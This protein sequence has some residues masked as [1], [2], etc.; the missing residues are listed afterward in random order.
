MLRFFLLIAVYLGLLNSKE[1]TIFK[2]S[3]CYFIQ[4]KTEELNTL[5]VHLERKGEKICVQKVVKE[6]INVPPH[7][8]TVKIFV[9]NKLWKEYQIK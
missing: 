7:I 8:K 3:P 4:I 9:D 6:V 2:P 5:F 1:V